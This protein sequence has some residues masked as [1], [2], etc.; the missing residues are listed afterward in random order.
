MKGFSGVTLLVLVAVWMVLAEA[1]KPAETTEPQRRIFHIEDYLPA[2]C[3][4]AV[5]T[6]ID[7]QKIRIHPERAVGTFRRLAL[8]YPRDSA[9]FA[10]MKCYEGQAWDILRKSDSVLACYDDAGLYLEAHPELIDLRTMSYLFSGWAH[11]YKNNRLTANYYF[12]KAGNELEDTQYVKGDA[13]YIVSGYSPSSR[14][15]LFTEIAGHAHDAG[16]QEQARHYIQRAMTTA[17]G[18]NRRSPELLAQALVEA[19]LIYTQDNEPD[20]GAAFFD[21]A[22]PIIAQLR[23]T[24]LLVTYYDHLGEAFLA[25]ARYDSSLAAYQRLKEIQDSSSVIV[26][27]MAEVAKGLAASYVGLGRAA[28]ARE[29]ISIAYPALYADTTTS[30]T[31]RQAFARTYLRYLLHNTAAAPVFDRFVSLS[32]SVFDRQR[33]NAISDMDAQYGLQKKEARI[34]ML[35]KENK[36]YSERVAAQQTMLIVSI[37]IIALLGAGFALLQQFQRRKQLQAERNKAV[38]EQQLLRSQMEPHFIFNTISVLQSLVRKNERELSIKYLSKFA[39]LLRISL[40]NAREAFVPV[41]EEV[42]AL[43]HYLSLQQIRFRDVFDYEIDTYEGYEDEAA[44]LL[45]PPMLLQ[46]FV[47]NAVQHGMVG[48]KDNEGLIRIIIRKEAQNLRFVIEDNGL[49][50]GKARQKDPAKKNSVS[51]TITRERLALLSRQLHMPASLDVIRRPLSQGGGMRVTL[52][53]PFQ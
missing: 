7:S 52:L 25:T 44:G 23:D 2:D 46:P 4:A 41:S 33:L 29:A 42:E 49:D 35:N 38:L 24:S 18:L 3:R 13:G 32:D 21:E 15:S 48:M 19:G 9:A 30:L 11:Y 45:I 27:D 28:E 8:K 43:Q 5:R 50:E 36:T 47:E 26:F 12:N 31:D 22:A 6:Y 17:R 20:S 39:R 34:G 1:C 14:V 53:I 10:V 51:T 40:E 37:L 16:L